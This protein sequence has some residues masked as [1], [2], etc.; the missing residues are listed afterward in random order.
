ML[1]LSWKPAGE[2]YKHYDTIIELD[3]VCIHKSISNI[4]IIQT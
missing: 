1:D 3:S 4:A 2:K